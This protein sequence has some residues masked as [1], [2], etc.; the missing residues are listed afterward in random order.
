MAEPRGRLLNILGVAFGL[1]GAVGGT[2]GGGILRTP[3]LVAAELGSGS[4]VLLA[5]F[6]GVLA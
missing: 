2:I 1:A 6:L 4:A 5:W 3:G